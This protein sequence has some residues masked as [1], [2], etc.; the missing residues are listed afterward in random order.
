MILIFLL[1]TVN[2]GTAVP[3]PQGIDGYIFDL[4]GITEVH[5]GIEVIINNTA[6]GHSTITTTGRGSHTGR[7]AAALQGNNGDELTITARNKD[8]NNTIHTTLSGVMHNVNM[9]LNMTLRP[10]PPNITSPA[11]YDA[12]EDQ[13]YSF[14][15][16]AIDDNFDTL[17][18]SLKISPEDM[19]INSSTGLITWYPDNDDVGYNDVTVS[20]SDDTFTV[21]RSYKIFCINT[22]DPVVITSTPVTTA[23]TKKLYTYQVI[24]DD[25]DKANDTISYSLLNA[26]H[27]MTID[28][29]TGKITW[30]PATSDKVRVT[31]QASDGETT[32]TQSFTIDIK[33]EKTRLPSTY[34]MY[35]KTSARLTPEP[36][37][38]PPLTKISLTL[39]REVHEPKLS[40]KKLYTRPNDISHAPPR[41]V[42]HYISI[43]KV[44]I[45]DDDIDNATIHFKIEKGE[46]ENLNASA[47]DVI[48]N[49]YV[50]SVWT[51]LPT[52]MTGEDK[53]FVYYKSPTPGFSYFA[54]SLKY[55]LIPDKITSS[56]VPAPYEI[57]GTIFDTKNSQVSPN[58]LFS[59][60]N[61]RTHKIYRGMTGEGANTG[62]YAALIDGRIGDELQ[63]TF[64]NGDYSQTI[65]MNLTGDMENLDFI[66]QDENKISLLDGNVKDN[67][68][69]RWLLQALLVSLITGIYVTYLIQNDNEK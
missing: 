37:V 1:V 30:I 19:M 60:L 58:T 69:I 63:F 13:P 49:R 66:W 26:P 9:L 28:S 53:K 21:N 14:Q 33:G 54:I 40:I 56:V 42:L 34:G 67:V 6:T 25:I 46:L 4:D 47:D 32:D 18:Y 5:E 7:Y 8:N 29:V 27:L 55:A 59:I 24:A 23:H 15:V 10:Y 61:T 31:V 38:N 22:N 50:D 11:P 62:A 16:E 48:L 57:F 43:D 39:N 64:Y 51:E 68:D 65:S 17:N 52:L 36:D 3:V 12:I 2:I 41:R 35:K 45:T 20:I 44:S